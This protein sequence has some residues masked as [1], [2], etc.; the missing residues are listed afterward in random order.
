MK[1]LTENNIMNEDLTFGE[2]LQIYRKRK[3]LTISELGKIVGV[4]EATI[5]N[6]EHNR[7]IPSADTFH[8]LI[9]ATDAPVEKLLTALRDS[10][11][12]M[13]FL[14]LD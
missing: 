13:E 3:R 4:S 7:S 8:K 2:L 11:A 12:E 9:R 14:R 6:Y 5:A 10:G 1:E